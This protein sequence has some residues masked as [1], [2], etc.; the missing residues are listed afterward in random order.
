MAVTSD[1]L[2]DIVTGHTKRIS[3]TASQIDFNHESGAKHE[4]MGAH[5][6]LFSA[7]A[8]P[9]TR[10]RGHNRFTARPSITSVAAAS[11][12]SG[13]AS[14]SHHAEAAMPNSGTSKAIGA[15]I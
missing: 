15:M 5:S 6:S 11:F 8:L 12:H 10:H 2:L 13:M 1:R 7:Y 4:S 9:I 14:D 3:N